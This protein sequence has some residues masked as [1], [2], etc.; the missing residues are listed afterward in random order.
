MNYENCFKD[1]FEPV[2]DYRK[3]VLI[4]FLIKNDRDFLKEYG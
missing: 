2:P 4:I 1:M 3:T